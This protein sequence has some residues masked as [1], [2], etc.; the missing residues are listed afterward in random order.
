M[1]E[2][3]TVEDL[4]EKH[5]VPRLPE[6]LEE[7][8]EDDSDETE[9]KT[10]EIPAESESLSN[11]LHGPKQL[12]EL[13]SEPINQEEDINESRSFIAELQESDKEDD[14]QEANVAGF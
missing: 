11:E 5:K 3:A 1:I 12:L 7:D 6:N 13:V 2:S 9:K 14:L 8:F 4:K 10:L